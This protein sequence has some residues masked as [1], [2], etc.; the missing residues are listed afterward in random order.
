M[1]CGPMRG[2]GAGLCGGVA[3]SVEGQSTW[4][5]GTVQV[6]GTGCAG[7]ACRLQHMAARW[8]APRTPAPCVAMHYAPTPHAIHHPVWPPA[9]PPRCG[10]CVLAVATGHTRQQGG[11][12]GAVQACGAPAWG[13]MGSSCQLQHVATGQGTPHVPALCT[14]PYSHTPCPPVCYATP[15]T[16][17]D[18]AS[19]VQGMPAGCGCRPWGWGRCRAGTWVHG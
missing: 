18:H 17:T 2:C 6:V 4:M 12:E 8:G 5:Q 11:G 3:R 14:A 15:H 19:Q 7:R 10:E 9:M 16:A 13:Y 1:A